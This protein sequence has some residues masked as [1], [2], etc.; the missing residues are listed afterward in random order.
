MFE[1]EP[2]SLLAECS[3]SLYVDYPDELTPEADETI[4][5]ADANEVVKRVVEAVTALLAESHLSS[6]PVFP[7]RLKELVRDVTAKTITTERFNLDV[8]TTAD[9]LTK[10]A[11]H[12]SDIIAP[13]VQGYIP[14]LPVLFITTL[15]DV[16]CR[17][18]CVVVTIHY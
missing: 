14:P 8:D 6:I 9:V 5:V 15:V 12:I 18:D 3:I 7:D 4:I 11:N 16:V 2:D 1:F 17:C 10:F 13:I